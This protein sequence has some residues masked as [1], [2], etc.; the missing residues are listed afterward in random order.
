MNKNQFFYIRKTDK[1]GLFL[2]SFNLD[3]VIRTVELE[4]GKRLV[5]LNDMHERL[6]KVPEVKNNKVVRY[7]KERN[8]F[9]SEIYLEKEDAEKFVTQYNN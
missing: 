7:N 3:L 6:E 1:G 9:Q 4:E 2:D 8:T 5:L